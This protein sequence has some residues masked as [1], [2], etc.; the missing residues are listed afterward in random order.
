M[1]VYQSTNTPPGR[2]ATAWLSKGVSEINSKNWPYLINSGLPR[3]YETE[4]SRHFNWEKISKVHN[5]YNTKLQ[6]SL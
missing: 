6:V 4:K 2:F 3:E 5:Y 1:Q